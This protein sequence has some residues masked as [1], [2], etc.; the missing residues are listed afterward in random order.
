MPE[1]PHLAVLIDADNVSPERLPGLLAE[2]ARYGDA[3]VR[4]M[5]GDWTSDQLKGWKTAANLH[6]ITDEIMGVL[7]GLLSEARGEP[8]PEAGGGAGSTAA[9]GGG[10]RRGST[11]DGEV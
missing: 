1:T 7:R 9:P 4:R 3:S 8:V 5:Y 10:A 6:A 11:A 2:V